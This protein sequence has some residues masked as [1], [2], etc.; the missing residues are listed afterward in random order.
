MTL[1][2]GFDSAWTPG[3]SGS[4]AGLVAQ[5]ADF[6]EIAPPQVVNYVEA[7]QLILD[8]QRHF[9]PKRTII[10]LDQ[11]TIVN[12]ATGSRPVDKIVCPSVSLRLGGMQPASHS[13]VEM[14]GPAAPVWTF[15]RCFGGAA[16]PT[17]PRNWHAR[18]GDLPRPYVN[19]SQ[20]APTRPRYGRHT[21]EI[22]SATDKNFL[23]ERLEIRL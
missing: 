4:I 10:L 20:M 14:F 6:R 5:G 22:Q 15:L 8:W 19:C 23:P 12:N 9:Q 11:P 2:V 21:A 18:Y 13:R 17:Q 7:E 3:N 16:D 1:L